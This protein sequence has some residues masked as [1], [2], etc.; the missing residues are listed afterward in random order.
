MFL[1]SKV[2]LLKL[3]NILRVLSLY[4]MTS[5]L[6]CIPQTWIWINF[7]YFKS[8]IS[9][10]SSKSSNRVKLNHKK[11]VLSVSQ[12]K[13][14]CLQSTINTCQ[15]FKHLITVSWLRMTGCSHFL[16]SLLEIV[17]PRYLDIK[18]SDI[19]I[20]FNQRKLSSKTLY[21]K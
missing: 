16:P 9:D 6:W 8:C 12:C 13:P 21:T 4:W 1:V 10:T 15:M 11:S 7:N 2:K 3:I 5:W 20:I 17:A 19:R 18:L 14:V